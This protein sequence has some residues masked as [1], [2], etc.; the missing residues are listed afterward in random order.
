MNDILSQEITGKADRIVIAGRVCTFSYPMHNTILYK[1]L[2][3]ESLFNVESW[4]KISFEENYKCWMACVW[5]GMH[6]QLP[7]DAEHPEPYWKAPFSFAE[8]E[9]LIDMSNAP[10]V[11]LAMFTSLTRWMPKKKKPASTAEAQKKTAPSSAPE[12]TAT[13]TLECSGPASASISDSTGFSS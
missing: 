1:Q 13:P 3:G 10:D 6:E 4:N 11:H 12:A 9:P 7:P 5:A 2:T 8:L